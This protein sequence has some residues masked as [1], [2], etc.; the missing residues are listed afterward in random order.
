MPTVIVPLSSTMA[1]DVAPHS[2]GKDTA[3]SLDDSC[4]YPGKETMGKMPSSRD[5]GYFGVGGELI[6]QRMNSSAHLGASHDNIL[7]LLE[8]C[9]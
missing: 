9:S 5:G 6:D 1:C 3:T 7:R 2:E 8:V 4:R